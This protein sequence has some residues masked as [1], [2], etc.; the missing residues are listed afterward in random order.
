[1]LVKP[2]IIT[3]YTSSTEAKMMD[4]YQ[5]QLFYSRDVC[6]F[7]DIKIKIIPMNTSHENN[8]LPDDSDLFWIMYGFNLKKAIILLQE[9]SNN[10][11]KTL[12]GII[13]KNNN[14]NTNVLGHDKYIKGIKIDNHNCRAIPI[15]QYI[16][17][18]N[19]YSDMT[20]LTL[21]T[22]IENKATST[23]VKYINI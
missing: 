16:H 14:D 5:E 8:N 7:R 10:R 3:L 23:F 12:F 9:I 18:F 21:I 6:N 15:K 20:P 2:E 4:L 17:G 1:M 13:D 11:C 19:L 22:K